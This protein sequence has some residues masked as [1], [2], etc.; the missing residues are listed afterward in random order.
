MISVI[1]ECVNEV[2]LLVITVPYSTDVKLSGQES[3]VLFVI[4]VSWV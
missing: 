4:Q 2:S 3:Q 1:V